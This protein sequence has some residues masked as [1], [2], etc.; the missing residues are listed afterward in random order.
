MQ[1]D[2]KAFDD[3]ARNQI[4]PPDSSEHRRIKQTFM[5][6]LSSQVKECY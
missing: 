1:A 4:K 5:C 2:K 6:G 3:R